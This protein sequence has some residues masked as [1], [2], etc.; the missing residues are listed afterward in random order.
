M[1]AV[2]DYFIRLGLDLNTVLVLAGVLLGGLAL[3][4]FLGRFIFGRASN[5][6]CAISSTFAI[7]FAYLAVVI[8]HCFL[9][10]L[11]RFTAPL[12]FATIAND[13]L[14]FFQFE[15]TEIT[16]ICTELIRAIVLAF[17]VNIID[18]WMP[19][20]RNIFAWLFFRILTVSAAFLLHLLIHWL[21]NSYLPDNF[22]IYAPIAL[23]SILVL[24]L[25]TGCLKFLVGII[26]TG[27]NPVIAALYTFFFATI[28][29]KMLTR[30][31]LTTGILSA[32]VYA[33]AY[34]GITSLNISASTL[35]VYA[36]FIILFA[37]V[38]YAFHH[39][40]KKKKD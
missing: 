4:S 33:L 10:E 9:P 13:Q 23:L 27:V 21:C 20:C 36:P 12:P 7:I 26:L 29:G 1:D 30:A 35:P 24:L 31:V 15:G 28:A 11:Q 39:A 37:A 14:C 32:I 16:I 5:F 3:F 25:L 34:F 40:P 17:F 38:W 22:I 6:H 8:I 19:I 2:S 18:R